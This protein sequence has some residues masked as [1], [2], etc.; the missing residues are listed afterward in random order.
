MNINLSE[1]A[2]YLSVDFYGDDLKINKIVTDSRKIQKGNL[3]VAISGKKFDGHN[4]IINAIQ[5]GAIAIICENPKQVFNLGIPYITVKDSIKALGVIASHYKTGLGD[6]FTIG[7]TGTNGKTTVTKLT[8]SILSKSYKVSTTKGNF[9]NEIGLPLSIL[10]SDNTNNIQKCVYELG[11]SKINDIKYLT[12]ICR[13][14][15]TTLL[16]VSEAHLETFVNMDNLVKT[17]EEIFSHPNT[18]HIILNLDDKY[19]NKWKEMNLE[20][21]ITTISVTKN[22]DYFLKLTNTKHYIISTPKG[23]IKLDK[24]K[25][26]S[27]LPINILFSV[28]LSIESGSNISDV[29]DGIEDYSGTEGRFYNFISS[30]KSLVIDDSYNANPESMKSAI[31]QLSLAENTRLFVM[32]DMGELGKKSHEHHLNIFKLAKELSIEYLFY[33]GKFY[34]E[35]QSIF[36]QNCYTFTDVMELIKKINE[37]SNKDTTILIKASRYMNFDIIAKELK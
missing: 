8:H 33:M 14:N 16:N 30:N 29:V 18:N 34:K 31:Q 17:K 36:G 10:D 24:N 12:D 19:Y 26:K 11:A 5:H 37:I 4:Y 25:T 23:K 7:I 22:A 3:F 20:K 6:P 27:I 21:K 9:N 15:L 28:A 13:P 2:S 35:A 1:L 32:G